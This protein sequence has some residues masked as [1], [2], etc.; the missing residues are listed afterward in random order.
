MHKAWLKSGR[1]VFFVHGNFTQQ[2]AI[3]SV[4]EARKILNLTPVS[5]DTLA[6]IRCIQIDGKHHRVDL[7][8]EDKNNENSVLMSY[9]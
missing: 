4:D 5:K 6:A 7:N 3:Q 1:M 2:A 9:Y 8:V